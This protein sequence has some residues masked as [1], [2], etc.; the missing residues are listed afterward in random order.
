MGGCEKINKN[1]KK[2]R[3]DENGERLLCPDGGYAS[4]IHDR[5]LRVQWIHFSAREDTI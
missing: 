4:R 1:Q 2:H 5:Y 3:Q